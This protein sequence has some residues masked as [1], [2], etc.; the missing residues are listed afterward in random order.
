MRRRSGLGGARVRFQLAQI[1][2]DKR[3]MVIL[4]EDRRAVAQILRHRFGEAAVHRLI[5]LPILRAEHRLD[6]HHVTQRPQP[7]IREAAVVAPFFFVGQPDAM[8][9]VGG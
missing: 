8:Q 1:S 6:V 4:D 2:G 3:E 5:R 7:F 9:I